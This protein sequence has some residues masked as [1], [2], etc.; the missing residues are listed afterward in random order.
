[1]EI[2]AESRQDLRNIRHGS[3]TYLDN[4]YF[5]FSVNNYYSRNVYL[6]PTMRLK[7][8]ELEAALGLMSW[9]NV[10]IL[11]MRKLRP[12]RGRVLP[13]SHSKS[14]PLVKKPGLLPLQTVLLLLPRTNSCGTCE[15]FR[16]CQPALTLG[17]YHHKST[18]CRLFLMLAVSTV[19]AHRGGGE[20]LGK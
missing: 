19:M 1:M 11:Q 6:I 18:T 5:F 16:S 13:K 14:L 17:L 4:G 12:K 20:S 15:M 2:L 9:S 3:H 7:M 10:S 8:L